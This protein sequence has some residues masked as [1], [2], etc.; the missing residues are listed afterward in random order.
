MISDNSFLFIS[1]QKWF[2]TNSDC[3]QG[4]IDG[5]PLTRSSPSGSGETI[6]PSAAISTQTVAILPP[7]LKALVMLWEQLSTTCLH[8]INNQTTLLSPNPNSSSQA[9]S[10]RLKQKEKFVSF[11]DLD[12]N[13]VSKNTFI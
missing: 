2:Y 1:T 3:F 13:K 8:S 9:R 10:L 4:A 11:K 12:E 7:A 6:R 5:V